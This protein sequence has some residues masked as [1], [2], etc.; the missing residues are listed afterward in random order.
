MFVYDAGKCMVCLIFHLETPSTMQCICCSEM[1]FFDT[2][3]EVR[4]RMDDRCRCVCGLFLFC[5]GN[6]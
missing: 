5:F 6:I 4:Q 2:C 1:L 3:H